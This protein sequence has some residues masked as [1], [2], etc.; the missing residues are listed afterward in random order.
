M[1]YEAKTAARREN[2]KEAL[3]AAAERTIKIRGLRGLKARDLAAEAGC[4]V[5]AI[6]NVVTDLDDLI[7]AVNART[8]AALERALKEAGGAIDAESRDEKQA[9]RRLV[10]LGL[11]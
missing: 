3:V 6:Y 9:I 7:L 8:L 1:D 10:R 11:A 4:A 5:G 2:L